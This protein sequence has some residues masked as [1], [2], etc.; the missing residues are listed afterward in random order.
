MSKDYQAL[1]LG[2]FIAD[3]AFKSPTPGGGSVAAVVG[4]MGAALGHMALAYTTGKPA[5]AEHE[6]R[7]QRALAGLQQASDG[8]MD[9]MREDMAAYEEYAAARKSGDAARHKAALDR[10]TAVPVELIALVGAVGA[11]LD[12]MKG[13]TNPQLLSDLKAAAILIAAAARAAALSATANLAELADRKE[14]ER[15]GNRLD[16]MLARLHR[17]CEAVVHYQGGE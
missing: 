14:A 6:E 15:I 1:P 11:R 12:D 3:T 17:H 9:L 16:V 2:E 10:A 7:L 4:A 5:F 8:L 13:C